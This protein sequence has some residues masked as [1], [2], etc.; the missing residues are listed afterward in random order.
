MKFNFPNEAKPPWLPDPIFRNLAIRDTLDNEHRI[1]FF[2][3]RTGLVYAWLTMAELTGDARVDLWAVTKR[4]MRQR[5][6][7][8]HHP[9]RIYC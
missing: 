8:V 4:R 2:D 1:E 9:E 5:Y 3:R 6:F 7:I